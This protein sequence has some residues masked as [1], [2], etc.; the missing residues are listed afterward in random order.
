L[1]AEDVGMKFRA[2]L[3]L[4]FTFIIVSGAAAQTAAPSPG[5]MIGTEGV[6]RGYLLGPGDEITGRVLGEEEF[7]FTAYV[8]AD[9]NIMVPFFNKPIVAMC[10]T[11]RALRAD[12]IMLLEKQLRNPQFSMNIKANSRPPATVFGEVKTPTHYDL[13]RVATIY[14][15]LA[16]SGGPTE[17]AGGVVEVKRPQPPICA[18]E[19]DTK[20]WASAV[21]DATGVPTR[22]FSLSSILAGKENVAIFP[23]DVIQ[24]HKGPP[25][26]VIGEVAN[27]MGINIREDGLTLTEAVAKLG[28]LRR[29]AKS[30]AVKIHRLKNSDTKGDRE[31]LIANLDDIKNKGGKDVLLQPYDI[32]EIDVAKPSVLKQIIDVAIGA[33]K[34]V[35]T[36]TSSGI[37]YRVIQ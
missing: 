28:G 3:S 8:N 36:S 21:A 16:L 11:E 29:E 15:L 10:R 37:G 12:L 35:L 13:R 26:W 6:A 23:G 9:G 5:P 18:D 30:K 24:V 33:S 34:T 2:L 7:N 19:A 31:L 27:P 14:E 22:T 1:D 4:L 25:V 17:E 20:E 32:V